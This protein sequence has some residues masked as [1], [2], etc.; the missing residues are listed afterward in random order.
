MNHNLWLSLCSIYVNRV[1]HATRRLTILRERGRPFR[2]RRAALCLGGELSLHDLPAC[3]ICA[4]LVK[5]TLGLPAIAAGLPA[6]QP[7]ACRGQPGSPTAPDLGRGYPPPVYILYLYCHAKTGQDQG[8]FG[9]LEGKLEGEL[10][11]VL[12]SLNPRKRRKLN[13]SLATI[14][15]LS[16][17]ARRM[18]DKLVISIWGML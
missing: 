16:R 3:T 13:P 5:K 6:F 11:L 10:D 4:S 9:V 18:S 12:R 17:A 15:S 8:N 1:A 7:T 2:C 14:S